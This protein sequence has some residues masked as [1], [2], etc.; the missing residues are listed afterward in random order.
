VIGFGE[1]VIYRFCGIKECHDAH[2]IH[3]G[4]RNIAGAADYQCLGWVPAEMRSDV[5]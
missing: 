1:V 2:W 3:R 4:A 5:Q